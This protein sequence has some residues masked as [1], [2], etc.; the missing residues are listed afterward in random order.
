MFSRS[1][2]RRLITGLILSLLFQTSY[3]MGAFD[4]TEQQTSETIIICTVEGSRTIERDETTPPHSAHCHCQC[5]TCG[6]ALLANSTV[7]GLSIP[8][9]YPEKNPHTQINSAQLPDPR[10]LRP[11]SHAPPQVS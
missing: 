8:S 3:A 11:P 7:P 5:S 9:I 10:V 1:Q 4:W 2:I 6:A